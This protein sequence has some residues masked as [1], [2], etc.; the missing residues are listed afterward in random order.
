LDRFSYASVVEG[1]PVE[2]LDVLLKHCGVRD[3]SWS[4]IRH[5]VEFLDNQ[6]NSCESSIFCNEEIVGDVMSGLKTFVVKFMIRMSK[7]FATS[8]FKGLVATGNDE[9]QDVQID[10][11]KQWEQK[12]HPYLFLNQDGVSFTFVGFCVTRT[13]DLIDP[14][15]GQIIE[16]GAMTPQL[17]ASLLKNNVDLSENYQSWNRRTMIEKIGK[18]MSLE[19]TNDPDPSYVLTVDNVIKIMAIHMRFRYIT[20]V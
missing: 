16:H 19:W 18:V 2:C 5:F 15:K 3:P 6:L 9:L 17:Y 7:D 4:E 13:G 12:F 1:R 8:S 10:T 11:R 14:V 20:C